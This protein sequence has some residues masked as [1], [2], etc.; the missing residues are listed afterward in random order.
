[1]ISAS[2]WKQFQFMVKILKKS[3]WNLK[4]GEFSKAD[5]IFTCFL[6][7]FQ[8]DFLKLFNIE[9]G[10]LCFFATKVNL[11][12]SFELNTNLD[13]TFLD[14]ENFNLKGTIFSELSGCWS[15]ELRW[16]LREAKYFFH[17]PWIYCLSAAK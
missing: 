1:M 10:L 2:N 12:C 7:I 16:V 17:A 4:A 15:F 9:F 14:G 11:A 13:C 8:N 3:Y 6:N 5:H